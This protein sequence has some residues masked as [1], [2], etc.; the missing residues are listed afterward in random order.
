MTST[1]VNEFSQLEYH[2]PKAILQRL[3]KIEQKYPLHELPYEVASLRTRS[4]KRFG[5]SRQC[6]LFCYGLGAVSNRE[7][8]YADFEAGD[9]DFVARYAEDGYIN[10]VPIQMKE[11]VPEHVNPKAQLEQELTKLSKYSDSQN[12]VVAVHL[13]RTVQIKLQELHLPKL[14]I[15]ELWFFGA[16]TE[17]QSSWWL[18]GNFLKEWRAYEFNYPE[19]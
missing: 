5:E 14:S 17:D 18:I 6:A 19:S 12:L 7:I 10:Y 4:L 15:A 16:R 9:H 13:N 8:E 2:D 1:Q 3:R 11:F